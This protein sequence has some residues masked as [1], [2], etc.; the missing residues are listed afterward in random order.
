MRLL[1]RQIEELR[2]IAMNDAR[3][4][5]SDLPTFFMD[6]ITHLLFDSKTFSISEQEIKYLC[7]NRDVFWRGVEYFMQGRILKR[8]VRLDR[9]DLQL[10]ARVAGKSAPY[11]DVNLIFEG[12]GNHLRTRCT[13]PDRMHNMCKHVVAVLVCWSR[14]PRSFDLN[15]SQLVDGD[16]KRE[17][18]NPVFGE[19][20]EK[21]LSKFEDVIKLIP[22][23]SKDQDFDALQQVHKIMKLGV[24]DSGTE[25][26]EIVE[27][28]RLTSVVSA[29]IITAMDAKYDFGAMVL[30]N[31]ATAGIMGELLERFIE[32]TQKAPAPSA[33]GSL[34]REESM[35]QENRVAQ[36]KPEMPLEVPEKKNGSGDVSRSWDGILEE[37]AAGGG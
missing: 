14:K 25:K 36:T 16:G 10:Y 6:R 7:G 23:S 18:V 2:E 29:G 24:L 31:K 21:A 30:Y 32:R 22:H 12:G 26:R 11:Y 34:I 17:L 35:V 3:P 33:K 5:S 9:R 27:F 20:L 37:F 1:C 8:Q 19:R 28:A 15:V 4:P 13:C